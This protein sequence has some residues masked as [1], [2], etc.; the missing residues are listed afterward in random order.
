VSVPSRAGAASRAAPSPVAKRGG[1]RFAVEGLLKGYD[2]LLNLV[3]DE[4]NEY[5]RDADDPL[6]LTE[7]TRGLGLTVLRGTAVMMVSLTDGTE[8]IA[9]PFIAQE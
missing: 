8:E 1:V 9:N 6:R 4:T 7:D 2:Q 3:L 5:L